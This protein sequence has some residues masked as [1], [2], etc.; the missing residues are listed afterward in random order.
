MFVG[1]CVGAK[2]K[3]PENWSHKPWG[4]VDKLGFQ[5]PLGSGRLFSGFEDK[6]ELVQAQEKFRTL[7]AELHQVPPHELAR[8]KDTVSVKPVG[9]P[10]LALHVDGSRLGTFQIVVALSQTSFVVVPGTHLNQTVQDAAQQKKKQGK[11]GYL[12]IEQDLG[13]QLSPT[14]IPASPGDTLIFHG[15][16][17]H[18]SPAPEVET[19][20]T[21]HVHFAPT[22]NTCGQEPSTKKTKFNPT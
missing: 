4:G 19:R 9:A 12:N 11:T 3:S 17:V 16:L 22:N 1:A 14:R 15:G 8:V 13:L 20:F 2:A 10:A 5:K 6:R 21:A 18:G 7:V